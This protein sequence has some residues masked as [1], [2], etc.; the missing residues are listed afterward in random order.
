MGVIITARRDGFRR[1][2]IAHSAAGTF[3]PDGALT[4]DQLHAFRKDPQ[5]VVTEQVKSLSS[6]GQ[7]D[8]LVEEMGNTIA[9]LEYSLEIAND[10]YDAASVLLTAFREQQLAAPAL[11]VS[12]ARALEPADPTAEGVICIAGD[13]LLSLISKHLQP[14]QAS[15]EAPDDESDT[16]L[17]NSGSAEASQGTSQG[18][19]NPS[20]S[21]TDSGVVVPANQ[22]AEKS[23]GRAKRG[24]GKEADK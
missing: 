18:A 23:A 6:V 20:P 21:G 17:N 15:P 7:G 13:A 19:P 2:G 14:V 9:S 4:E 16:T 8:P 1:G 12:E 3:Y 5:L 24:S 22:G 10:Q 11:V